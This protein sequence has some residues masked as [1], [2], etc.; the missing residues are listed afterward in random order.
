MTSSDAVAGM[1]QPGCAG[2]PTQRTGL[3]IC[4][5]AMNRPF[6]PGCFQAVP[7]RVRCLFKVIKAYE[8]S[9]TGLMIAVND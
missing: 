9:A 4:G 7:I 3:P 6:F 2:C 5:F 1:E 8:A